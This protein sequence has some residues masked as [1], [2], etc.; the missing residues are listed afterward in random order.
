MTVDALENLA[1]FIIKKCRIEGETK[2]MVA[3]SSTYTWVD[4][5]SE[6]GLKKPD[7]HFLKSI[8]KLEEICKRLN[9]DK[10]FSDKSYLKRYI[11]ST[12]DIPLAARLKKLFFK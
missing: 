8:F 7:Q 4:E 1:G 11:S 6:D 2:Q 3:H 5:R 10:F 12:K 9:G